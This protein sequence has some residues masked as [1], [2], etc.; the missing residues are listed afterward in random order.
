[1]A[2]ILT[3]DD[4]RAYYRRGLSGWIKAVD[5]VSLTLAEGEILGIAGE[6]GCGKSTLAM[7][8]AS[9][10]RW[11]L[12]VQGGRLVVEGQA[13]P[14]QSETGRSGAHRGEVVS[15]M[16]QGA[17]NSLNP[18]QRVRDFVFDVLRSHEPHVTRREA[19]QRAQERLTKLDLPVRVLDAYP[20]QLS[21][22]MKQRVVA[23]ISTLLDPRVLIADEPTSALDVSAQRALLALLVQLLDQGIIGGIVLVTHELPILRNVAHRTMIMYAGQVCE[24]GPT[25]EVIFAPAHP[26]TKA[27]MDATLVLESATKRQRIEGLEGGPP[28]LSQPPSGCRFHPRCPHASPVCSKDLPPSVTPAPGHTAACWWLEQQRPPPPAAAEEVAEP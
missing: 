18:T 2:E 6:S 21:G 13:V 12:C 19:V 20:H 5:G 16:P 4:V 22:G 10:A 9:A 1:M 24:T 27:L 25:E 11:P 17:M 3:A 15:L 28:D 23:V 14:M 7:A 8:L 26:Y